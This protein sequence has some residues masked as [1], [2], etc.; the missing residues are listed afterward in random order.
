MNIVNEINTILDFCLQNNISDIHFEHNNALLAVR[1][2]KDGLLRQYK[3]YEQGQAIISRLKIMANLDINAHFD[4]QDGRFTYK[5]T[6]IRASAIPTFW[7][8]KIVLRLLIIDKELL[9]LVNLGLPAAIFEQLTKQLAKRSGLLIVAGPTGSGKTTTL[10]SVINLLQDT[11][12]NITTIE[13]PIEYKLDNINQAQVNKEK[14]LSFAVLLKAILRQDPDII[15][16]GEIRDRETAEIAVRAAMTGHLVLSTVHA[17]DTQ[18]TIL[19]FKDLGISQQLIDQTISVILSQ[20]L[21]RIFCPQ[22]QGKG[23]LHCDGEGYAGRTGLFEYYDKE[24]HI[25]FKESKKNLLN[26]KATSLAE[27]II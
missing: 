15:L 16:V 14:G 13:D 19:R 9:D 24:T 1:Y 27:V 5:N 20:R 25:S 4:C 11:K 3:C 22:C 12:F 26:K 7:G 17:K 23:C 2:R 10:Y 8:S 6:D 21:I 18:E